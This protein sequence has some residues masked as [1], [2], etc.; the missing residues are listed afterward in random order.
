MKENE[1]KVHSVVTSKEAYQ[2]IAIDKI[3]PNP[4][5]PRHS[6]NP[7]HLQELATSIKQSGIYQ[8][9]ILRQPIAAIERY[10]IIAGERRYRAS[11][12]A[13]LTK[14]PAIIR[15]FS[16]ETTREAAI[17]ENL[18]REDLSPLEEAEAYQAMIKELGLTQAQVSQ[19]LGK[20]RPYIAN[21]LRLLGLP[22]TVKQLLQDGKLS[23]G[24]ARTLLG[25]KQERQLK[26]MAQRTV[27]E[28]LTVR[29]LEVL[30]NQINMAKTK[31]A[32]KT[33]Q[34]RRSPFV[35]EIENQLAE[36]LGT[37]AVVMEK[38]KQKG[39]I[40]IDYESMQDLDRILEILN[41]SID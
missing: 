12:L 7:K 5:Q 39:K 8:P 31:K 4:F 20:S 25:L 22:T 40:E 14:V 19:R 30:V 36:K 27:K 6:F 2:M 34:R 16:D 11:K 33:P 38:S 29:Q 28:N 15:D 1:L 18:Q 9:L 32:R 13:G 23:M 26:Q 21:Y 24:Q 35:R 41:I 37:K 17:I 3:R 10:E